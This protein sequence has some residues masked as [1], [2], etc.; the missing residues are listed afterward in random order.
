V[1]DTL[2]VKALTRVKL[3][4]HVQERTLPAL[5]TQRHERLETPSKLAEPQEKR[6][7]THVHGERR[8]YCR[9]IEHLPTLVELRSVADRRRHKQRDDDETEHV[10]EKA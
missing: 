5:V 7:D 1:E 9:R 8:T 6:H 2:D 4:K 10:D 3:A